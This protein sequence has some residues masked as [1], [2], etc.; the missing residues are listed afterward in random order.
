LSSLRRLSIAR[1][2]AHGLI[3][4]G[5]AAI[6]DNFSP[7]DEQA[8]DVLLA[9]AIDQNVELVPVAGLLRARM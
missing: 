6:L 8:S 2:P 9:A 5:D 7:A 1:E 3:N 4:R